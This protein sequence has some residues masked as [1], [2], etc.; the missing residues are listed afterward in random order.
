M[1]SKT[2][3]STLATRGVTIW[4]TNDPLGSPVDRQEADKMDPEV[5]REASEVWEVIK[6]EIRIKAAV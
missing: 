2:A 3:L 5:K 1:L 4:V 6:E